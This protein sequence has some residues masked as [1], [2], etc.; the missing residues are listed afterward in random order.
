MPD[1][2]SSA[3]GTTPPG[4]PAAKIQLTVAQALVKF[5]G[6]QYSESNGE[7][8]KLLAGCFGIFGHGNVAGIGQA[9]LQ[10][11]LEE[12]D[13]LP[14]ILGRNEQAM[15]HTAVAYARIDLNRGP[16]EGGCGDRHR[17]RHKSGGRYH[18]AAHPRQARLPE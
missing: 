2:L 13:T 15:V 14:Y 6:A 5:L 7:E 3:G 10:A 9:L 8:Q 12:P 4:P 17:Q 18:S 1:T 11:E 16:R